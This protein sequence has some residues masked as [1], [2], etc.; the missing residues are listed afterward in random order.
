MTSP[1]KSALITGASSGIGAAFARVFA[2]EGYDLL[3]TGKSEDELKKRAYEIQESFSVEVAIKA[4]D[5]TK[6][7]SSEKLFEWATRAEPRIT[8]LVNCA[9]MGNYGKFGEI[10]WEKENELLQLN[11]VALTRLCHLFVPYFKEKKEGNILNVASMAGFQPGSYFAT[12]YASKSYVLLFTE[13][14][15]LEHASD[16]LH[17]SALCPGPSP[18]NF[19]RKAQFPETSFILRS[20]MLS[21]DKVARA[22]YKGLMEGKTVIIPSVKYWLIPFGSRLLP[23]KIA[24]RIS[25]RFVQ[26]AARG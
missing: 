1:K 9:G 8:C 14:L 23:R 10:P 7:E 18:T 26:I 24:A 22:G 17:I 11:I 15:A 3:L 25:K 13:A 5:I 6:P 12:Y 19:F 4:I 2:K 16:S 20:T 21:A